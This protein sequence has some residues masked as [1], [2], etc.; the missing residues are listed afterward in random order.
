MSYLIRVLLPDT[1]G[2]LGRLADAFGTVD[3]NIQ[4]VDVIEVFPDNTAMDDIVVN[5]PSSILPDTLITAAQQVNGVEVDSIRPFSGT[6]DRREQIAM[7]S[8]VANARGS[9]A[10]A[11]KELV[12]HVPRTMTSGWAI[13][14][15]LSDDSSKRIAASDSAPEDNG[16]SPII[17][18]PEKA[19]VL[20]PERESWIPESWALLDAAL[21]IA[22]I[23]N[24]NLVLVVGRPG[25]PD[26][27]ASEVQHLGNLGTI[28]G[29]MIT[30]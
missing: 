7:L 5:I 17:E 11:M 22:P 13:A 14:L 24:T 18:R 8:R 6:V 4:S 12:D 21:A 30:R 15:E 26:L 2:S 9:R 19:R 10:R 23:A 25:G 28:I 29:A 27:L 3:A 1:P 20:D 16:E